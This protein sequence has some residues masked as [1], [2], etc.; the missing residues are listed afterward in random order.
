[1]KSSER[2]K[3]WLMKSFTP[4]A[5]R[6]VYSV[7]VREG[8]I[9]EL[10]NN[11]FTLYGH[12]NFGERFSNRINRMAPGLLFVSA[13]LVDFHCCGAFFLIMRIHFS[14]TNP[15]IVIQLPSIP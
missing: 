8:K 9:P 14:N 1:M 15:R 2:F 3:T 12:R 7:A 6:T 11:L 4:E 13:G 5:Q 10:V